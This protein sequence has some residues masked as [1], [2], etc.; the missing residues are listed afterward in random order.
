M[1]TKQEMAD[2]LFR[3]YGALI[4]VTDLAKYLGQD[5]FRTRNRFVGLVPIGSGNGKRYFYKDVAA[6]ICSSR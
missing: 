3:L 5:R 2:D 6:A 1:S 4:S